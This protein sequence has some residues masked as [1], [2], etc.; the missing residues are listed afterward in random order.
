MKKIY[1]QGLDYL[2][3]EYSENELDIHAEIALSSTLRHFR[4]TKKS[5]EKWLNK[6]IAANNSTGRYNSEIFNREIAE[7]YFNVCVY[8]GTYWFCTIS[9]N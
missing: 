5:I 4:Y 6:L 9:E 2:G 3:V 1:I 7:Q 8:N